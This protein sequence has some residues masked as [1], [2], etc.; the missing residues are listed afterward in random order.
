MIF[1]HLRCTGLSDRLFLSRVSIFVTKLCSLYLTLL[2]SPNSKSSMFF[3]VFD[4]A[5]V[6]VGTTFNGAV[7]PLGLPL[8]EFHASLLKII[9]T[10]Q[11][12]PYSKLPITPTA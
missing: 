4:D 9:L 3:G 12:E 2:R 7:E 6:A 11:K 5:G 8:I 1:V 10:Y